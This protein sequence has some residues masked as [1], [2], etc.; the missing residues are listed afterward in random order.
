MSRGFRRDPGC[1]R[2]NARCIVLLSGAKLAADG[3]VSDEPRPGRWETTHGV[4]A[5]I[6][7]IISRA[8]LC[9]R[10]SKSLDHGALPK[11]NLV[12][13]RSMGC[14]CTFTSHPFQRCPL[15]WPI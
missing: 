10:V 6:R 1:P 5:I 7:E 4:D 2:E 15:P 12:R 9:N 14:G 11:R 8:C 3:G 13:D